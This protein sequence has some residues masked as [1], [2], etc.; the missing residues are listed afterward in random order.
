MR[1]L[2]KSIAEEE[3]ERYFLV[4]RGITDAIREQTGMLNSKLGYVYLVDH[5]CRIRWAGSAEAFSGEKESLAKGVER[6]VRGWRKQDVEEPG[7][8]DAAIA[9]VGNLNIDF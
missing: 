4:R 6:L 8:V 7:I 2:R 9:A 5:E 1:G 3:H